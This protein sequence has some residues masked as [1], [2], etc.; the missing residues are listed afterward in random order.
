MKFELAALLCAALPAPQ[1][2]SPRGLEWPREVVHQGHAVVAYQPQVDSWQDYATLRARMVIEV[3]GEGQDDGHLGV[4]HMRAVTSTDFSAHV[5]RV[6]DIEVEE[7]VYP[8]VAEVD[9][10]A[11]ERV[12]RSLFGRGALT[13][14]LDG[15]LSGLLRGYRS[16]HEV[17]VNVEPPPIFYSARPAVLVQFLGAP[18]FAP[19]PGTGLRF[20]WNTNWDVLLDTETARYFVLVGDAWLV[21]AG[22]LEGPWRLATELPSGFSKLPDDLNWARARAQVPGRRVG[23]APSVVITERPAELIVTDGAPVMKSVADTGLKY[24]ANTDDELFRWRDDYYY[25]VAGRWFVAR[26]LDGPW[27]AATGELPGGFGAIPP[28]HEKD[29]VLSSV[30]GTRQAREAV[31]RASIPRKV[32]MARGAEVSVSYD[33]APRFEP[34]SGTNVSCAVNT[35][36]DV[37]MVGGTDQAYLCFKGAWFEAKAASGPWAVCDEPPADLYS[38]PPAHPKHHVTYVFAYRS[39]PEAVVV[40]YTAGY[41]GTFVSHGVPMFGT[42]YWSPESPEAEQKW[43]SYWPGYFWGYGAS[44]RY[45]SREGAFFRAPMRYG[46]HGGAGRGAIYEPLRRTWVRGDNAYGASGGA[47]AEVGHSPWGGEYGSG[48]ERS[49]GYASWGEGVVAAADGAPS[50]GDAPKQPAPQRPALTPSSGKRNN[51]FVD[52]EGR[53]YKAAPETA[54]GWLK[55]DDGQWRP[56]S[57]A[58]SSTPTTQRATA[59]VAVNARGITQYWQD[60]GRQQYVRERSVQAAGFSPGPRR[61]DSTLPNYIGHVGWWY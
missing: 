38:I 25:L 30:P 59:P 11:A 26:S 49:Q 43:L 46:P 20:A 7:V 14:S 61:N 22:G 31:I 50:K 40:G 23:A 18:R 44:A 34:V 16:Q 24:I 29:H 8:A 6:S 53:I 12:V 33:G 35:R 32:T 58:R 1:D 37:F 2:P 56:V 19:L 28:G 4:V 27:R 47:L 45:S 48:I 51:V 13:M 5:V 3:R 10:T 55:W 15:V 42:G 52:Q 60:L 17:R 54:T 39:T 21:S 57:M 36:H 9:V 41:K